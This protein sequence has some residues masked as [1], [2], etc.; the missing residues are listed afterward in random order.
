MIYIKSVY[1]WRERTPFFLL[2]EVTC[3]SEESFTPKS[4]VKILKKQLLK[5]LLAKFLYCVDAILKNGLQVEKSPKCVSYSQTPFIKNEL[6]NIYI[7]SLRSGEPLF[8][9]LNS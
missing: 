1:N 4:V 9:L 6:S 7:R 5:N 3:F 8:F 2:D